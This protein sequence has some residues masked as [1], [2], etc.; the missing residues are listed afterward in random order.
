MYTYIILKNRFFF[1][2]SPLVIPD[3]NGTLALLSQANNNSSSLTTT[4]GGHEDPLPVLLPTDLRLDP[5][6]SI[7]FNWFRFITIGICPFVLLVLLN[8]KIYVSLRQRKKRAHSRRSQSINNGNN[9]S[10]H[11]YNYE[12]KT[13]IETS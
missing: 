12:N 9:N 5:Y 7:Y 4:G 2:I 8:T 1:S 10:Y 13:K 11:A 3:I 6:Y